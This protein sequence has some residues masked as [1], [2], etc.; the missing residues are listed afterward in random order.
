MNLKDIASLRLQ[1]QQLAGTSFKKP[2]DLVQWMGALQ[3]QD[4]NMSKWAVGIRIPGTTDQAIEKAISDGKIIRT[5]VLRPTWHLVSPDDIHWMLQLTAPHIKALTKSRDKEL[6]LTEKL[7]TKSNTL[8]EKTLSKNKHLTREELMAELANHHIKAD[9]N[10]ASHLMIRAELEGIVCS[11]KLKGKTHTY[12]LLDDLIKSPK[13]IS[14]EEALAKLASIYFFSHAP[15]TLKDFSWWSGLSLTDSKTA[16]ESIKKKLTEE[17]IG[18]ETYWLPAA[19]KTSL[20]KKTSAHFLP[21]FDEYII[22]YKDRTASLALDH[23]PVAFTTNGIFRPILLVDGQGIGIWSRTIKKEIITIEATFFKSPS[24]D[25]RLL[26][27]REAE[28]Y[29]AFLNKK[30]EVVYTKS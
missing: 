22:S 23:Q 19:F 8:I 5:H 30:T 26:L 15:A 21:A 6:E 14:R 3:A 1:S 11:G 7:Y 27:E 4:Y 17:K 12:T 13:K 10:R 9:G 18:A 2:Q 24:K 28:L 16:L 20:S 25:A 29:G